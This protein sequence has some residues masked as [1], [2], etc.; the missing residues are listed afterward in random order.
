MH[1]GHWSGQRTTGPFY[2]HIDGCNVA[3]QRLHGALGVGRTAGIAPLLMRVGPGGNVRSPMKAY[4]ATADSK[5]TTRRAESAPAMSFASFLRARAHTESL[6]RREFARPP[7]PPETGR[8]VWDAIIASACCVLCQL[9]SLRCSG[10]NLRTLAEFKTTRLEHEMSAILPATP[11]S[12]MPPPCRAIGA[13]LLLSVLNPTALLTQCEDSSGLEV[14]L[15]GRCTIDGPCERFPE[16][17]GRRDDN[18]QGYFLH[19]A[20]IGAELCAL[21]ARDHHRWCGN[22]PDAPV[23]ASFERATEHRTAGSDVPKDVGY[24]SFPHLP[25]TVPY[26]KHPQPT[27]RGIVCFES[28]QIARGSMWSEGLCPFSGGSTAHAWSPGAARCAQDERQTSL[29]LRALEDV[30][31]YFCVRPQFSGHEP[32]K[33]KL[34]VGDVTF[35]ETIALDTGNV[36]SLAAS[37]GIF[38]RQ[39]PIDHPRQEEPGARQHFLVCEWPFG[40]K[41][42]FAAGP[43]AE[44]EPADAHACCMHDAEEHLYSPHGETSGSDYLL[45]W[46]ACL[47]LCSGESVS[48]FSWSSATE[49]DDGEWRGPDVD[50][51]GFL[52]TV[53]KISDLITDGFPATYMRFLPS[54]VAAALDLQPAHDTRYAPPP[55]A[56][57][58]AGHALEHEEEVAVGEELREALYLQAQFGGQGAARERGVGVKVLQAFRGFDAGWNCSCGDTRHGWAFVQRRVE[59][60]DASPQPAFRLSQGA[61]QLALAE[62]HSETRQVR[63]AAASSSS[64]QDLPGERPKVYA[65]E[66]LERLAVLDMDRLVR[67]L[68]MVRLRRPVLMITTSEVQQ[69]VARLLVGDECQ[70][71]AVP[72]HTLLH[73]ATLQQLENAAVDVL[74]TSGAN[75]TEVGPSSIVVLALGATA[76]T[77]LQKRLYTR[78][79]SPEAAH[80]PRV[81]PAVAMLDLTP[82]VELLS[83][84]SSDLISLGRGFSLGAWARESSLDAQSLSS[85]LARALSVRARV[86]VLVATA[87]VEKEHDFWNRSALYQDTF[88]TLARQGYPLVLIAEAVHCSHHGPDLLQRYGRVAYTCIN[89]AHFMGNQGVNEARSLLH[90]MTQLAIPADSMLV[91]LTGR[92]AFVD[93]S[94]FQLLERNIE[95]MDGMLSVAPHK[96]LLF[97]GCFAMR[98][99][100]LQ[101]AL[102]YS[103][104]NTATYYGV[105]LEFL[106]LHNVRK[107]CESRRRGAA[108]GGGKDRGGGSGCR[109]LYVPRL[110]VAARRADS[111]DAVVW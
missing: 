105:H 23:H 63:R 48:P 34:Y 67:F 106:V 20:G 78:I 43:Q 76:S 31:V 100:L 70:V 45:R 26:D 81:A 99:A 50:L 11:L 55:N 5:L 62:K 14:R 108:W 64:P 57:A 110:G 25:S 104:W 82:V 30:S 53:D 83:G 107:T 77:I 69:H 54:D 15:V 36:C 97:T 10:S 75:R 17:G 93:R 9:G 3:L 72:R 71:L 51:V 52:D 101:E 74:V 27:N 56:H 59:C 40:A 95:A 37:R 35:E 84:I 60:C 79:F 33:Y 92:Y 42:H 47:H 98:A 96:D 22:H 58:G 90:A 73:R 38:W 28:Y 111:P 80:V 85:R 7:R 68:C 29:R 46:R 13:L 16:Q 32:V 66:A 87:L 39:S 19:N 2:L 91:K 21:R 65:A 4:P 24:A 102:Q 12:C 94:F 103:D 61:Q 41:S 109:L 18:K 49:K 89:D 8:P 6:S 44:A 86:K 88:R 1:A